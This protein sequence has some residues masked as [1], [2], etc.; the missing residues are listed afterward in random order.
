VILGGGFG[1]LYAAL[2]LDRTIARDPGIEVILIDPQ[3]FT[4]F[5]PMLHEVASGSLD[6]SSIIVPIRQALRRVEFLE[7]EATAIDF[8]ARTVTVLYGLEGR[9]A[10][11]RFDQ[12]LI[13]VGS[14]TRFPPGL[15]RRALGMKTIYDALLLRNWLI[16]TLERAEIEDD[17]D[18]RRAL[19]I[20]W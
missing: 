8:A 18:H 12:L 2:Y 16:G 4:V 9:T 1:G 19:L 13:A 7:A 11:I 3:N 20:A 10:A 17:A 15:R 5:T 6:P 14:Q